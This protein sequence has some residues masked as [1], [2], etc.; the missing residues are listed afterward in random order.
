[1]LSLHERHEP[2]DFVTVQSMSWS[3]AASWQEVGG[4][5]YHHRPDLSSTPSSINVDFYARIVERTALLRRLITAATAD[6]RPWPTTRASDVDDR[7]RQAPR[8]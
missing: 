3:G 7:H 5:A 1:M 2:L 8:R 4:P 6:R